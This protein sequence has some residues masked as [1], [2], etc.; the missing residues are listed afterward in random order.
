MFPNLDS[1]TH[2]LNCAWQHVQLKDRTTLDFK[3]D[4]NFTPDNFCHTVMQ[5]NH[6]R[7]IFARTGCANMVNM[8][9]TSKTVGHFIFR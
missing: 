2:I 6:K 4:T 9:G 7:L 8:G 1:I 5:K 3:T